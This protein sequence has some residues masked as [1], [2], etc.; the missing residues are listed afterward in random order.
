[1]IGVRG[2]DDIAGLD[3]LPNSQKEQPLCSFPPTHYRTPT[4]LVKEA[5]KAYDAG[6]Y[7]AALTVA[8]TIPDICAK[9][10]SLSYWKWCDVYFDGDA[11]SIYVAPELFAEAPEVYKGICDKGV[12][13]GSVLNQLRCAVL[14]SGSS[15]VEGAGARFSAFRCLEVCVQ[16]DPEPLIT[17]IGSS[18]HCSKDGRT[19]TTFHCTIN[20]LGLICRLER[21]VSRFVEEDPSRDREYRGS[22]SVFVEAG[23]VDYRS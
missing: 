3:L 16:D 17:C 8:V 2:L 20:L 15:L 12:L 6:L 9:S 22:D 10:T 18:R 13:T 4:A 23:I 5:R 7:I 19:T 11:G 14:H 1:M 21:A